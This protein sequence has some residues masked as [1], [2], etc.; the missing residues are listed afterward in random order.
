MQVVEKNC[1]KRRGGIK[2]SSAMCRKIDGD[3]NEIDAKKK[4]ENEFYCS[5]KEHAL[6]NFR[7]DH[8]IPLEIFLRVRMARRKINGWG[9]E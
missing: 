6:P 2:K 3:I 5:E 7:K 8:S 9:A 4:E 1:V